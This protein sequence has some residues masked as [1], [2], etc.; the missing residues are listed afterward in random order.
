MD[1]V[2]FGGVGPIVPWFATVVVVVVM[3]WLLKNTKRDF[4][5]PRKIGGDSP[6]YF[7]W[8]WLVFLGIFNGGVT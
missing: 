7:S 3:W 8:Y 1:Y 5:I 4:E 6:T 2:D